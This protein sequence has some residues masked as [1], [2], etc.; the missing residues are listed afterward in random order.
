MFEV[1]ETVT[2]EKESTKEH[3][4]GLLEKERQQAQEREFA[5]KKE[6]TTK[7]NELEDQYN[8]LK[9]QFGNS[10]QQDVNE[11]QEVNYC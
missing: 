4:E 7:L 9:E 2:K 8:S 6:F 5:M 1:L 3:Y 10:T 11:V